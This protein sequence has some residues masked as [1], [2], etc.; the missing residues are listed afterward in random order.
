MKKY[1][2]ECPKCGD[3][4]ESDIQPYCKTCS[5][6]ERFDVKMDKLENK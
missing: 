3:T 5:H 2:W 4:E 6:I 1:K